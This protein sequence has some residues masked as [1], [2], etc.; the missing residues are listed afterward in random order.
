MWRRKKFILVA[1]VIAVVLVASVV[2]IGCSRTGDEEGLQPESGG[3][4]PSKALLT[5]VTEILGTDQQDLQDAFA[6]TRSEMPN[7][8][9][10]QRP[11]NGNPGSRGANEE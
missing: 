7:G 11:A 3:E 2:G 8:V 9:P 1:T 4:P 6:Q 5:R 10:G